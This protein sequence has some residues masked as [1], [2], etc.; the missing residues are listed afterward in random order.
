[1][2]RFSNV[3]LGLMLAA[4]LFSFPAAATETE[5]GEADEKAIVFPELPARF[6]AE[7][8]AV[9]EGDLVTLRIDDTAQ[10]VRIYGVDSPEPGQPWFEKAKEW[11]Q[12]KLSGRKVRAEYA[13]AD[14]EGH[15]VVRLFLLPAGEDGSEE[16]VGPELL[17]AGM[18]W[19][20]RSNAPAA[21]ELKRR[22]AA[23]LS[24][25]QGLW[26]QDL[27]LAPWDYRKSNQEPPLTYHTRETAA[28]EPAETAQA[29]PERP[30]VLKKKG[31]AEYVDQP[32]MRI[33]P[34]QFQEEDV[35]VPRL[36]TRHQPHIAMDQSGQPIGFTA[37]DIS[38]IPYARQLG[39]QDGDIITSVNGVPLNDPGQVWG[40]VE[41][42]KNT[43]SFEVEVM[44]NGQVVRRRFQ[45]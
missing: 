29:E 17:A 42:F 11:A 34:R 37:S 32:V 1:M 21:R 8:T 9:P 33:N 31:N 16:P 23:A 26:S 38:Q 15:A 19:W 24:G 6:E 28:P 7:I 25:K 12:K 45:L 27:P 4:E 2:M 3:L 43:K 36:M 40:L 39:F 30:K 18:G 10:T 13:A 41:R 35:D 44:R 22:T 20:D 5:T 14:S